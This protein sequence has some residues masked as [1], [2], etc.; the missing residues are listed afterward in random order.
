MEFPVG[1]ELVELFVGNGK[2]RAMWEMLIRD[3]EVNAYLASANRMA[4]GRLRYNDHGPVHSRIVAGSALAIFEVLT[5]RGFTPDI[6]RFGIGDLED[7]RLVTMAIA[8]LHD[9]GNSIHR[10]H[11]PLFSVIITDKLMDKLL[12]RIYSDEKMYH[13]KQEILHGVFCH[14]EAYTCLT[15]ES[16][17][18]KIADGTDMSEGRARIPYSAGKK[19]IHAVSAMSIRRVW[20]TQGHEKPLA[21]NVDMTSDAGIFQVDEVLGRKIATSGLAPHVEVRVH[22]KGSH[23]I[24]RVFETTHNIVTG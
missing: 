1:P 18:A 8:Y 5:S 14:D 13:V 4:V 16:A 23:W 9:I 3:A 15:V 12:P 10:T 22:V 24:T 20:I 21:I 17:M 6:V 19:D 2:L 7:A 11:H